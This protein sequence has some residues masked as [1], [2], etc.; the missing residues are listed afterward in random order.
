MMLGQFLKKT[1]KYIRFIVFISTGIIIVAVLKTF[2]DQL[3]DIESELSSIG[4]KLRYDAIGTYQARHP[5]FEYKVVFPKDTS[6]KTEMD[7]WGADGW[8][9]VSTRRARDNATNEY[10]YEVIMKRLR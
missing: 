3:S 6:F 1:L 7:L 8:E 5:S 2:H 10:G 4:S 9:L